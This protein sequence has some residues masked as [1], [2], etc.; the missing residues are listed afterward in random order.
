MNILFL[1]ITITLLTCATVFGQTTRETEYE[2]RGIELLQKASNKI[3]DFTT[4]EVVFSYTMENTQMGIS[5]SMEGWV[6][7]MGDKYRMTVGDNVFISDGVNVWTFLSDLD[8]VHINTVENSE[9]GLSPTVLLD[10]F[11]NEYRAKF[12]RQENQ[13]GKVVDLIDLIPNTPQSFFKYRLVLD[14]RDQSLVNIIAYDRHG[15]TYTYSITTLKPNVT[16]DESSFRYNLSDFPDG[17]IE[18]D[19]R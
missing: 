10:N 18:V 9:G 17:V 19:L 14:A 4:M 3:K 5:E 7:A 8:E 12:I 6:I 13:N 1:T 16:A 2:L 15:G 11:A